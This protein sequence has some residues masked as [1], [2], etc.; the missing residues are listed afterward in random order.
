MPTAPDQDAVTA[1]AAGIGSLTENTNLFLGHVSD[2]D[3]VP[4]E[5]V[6]CLATGGPAPQDYGGQTA[7]RTS[8]S[9]IQVRVRSAPF[10]FNGGQVTARAVRDALHRQPPA[11]YIDV[12]AQQSDPLPLPGP[13]ESGRHEWS[14]NFEFWHDQ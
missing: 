14:V 3:G 11:G 4:D 1:L 10:D 13:D 2:G 7:L 8:F 5:A 12:L 9:A 6:F